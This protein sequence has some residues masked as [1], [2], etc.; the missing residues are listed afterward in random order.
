MPAGMN[1][2]QYRNS[3][4]DGGEVN[5]RPNCNDDAADRTDRTPTMGGVSHSLNRPGN[6]LPLNDTH[7]RSFAD[8]SETH[9]MKLG[10]LQR[11]NQVS[12]SL[13]ELQHQIHAEEVMEGE[14]TTEDVDVPPIYVS[15]PNGG[16][17]GLLFI[18]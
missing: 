18:V 9:T 16:F 11:E 8:L 14:P 2:I 5:F 6:A 13:D 15:T 1:E 17:A 4:F 7:K 3:H 10:Q 12:K